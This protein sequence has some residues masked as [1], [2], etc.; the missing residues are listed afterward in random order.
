MQKKVDKSNE[1]VVMLLMFKPS[2]DSYEE[3][4]LMSVGIDFPIGS[5][6]TVPFHGHWE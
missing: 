5:L 1:Y 2:L 6:Y 3:L 4:G